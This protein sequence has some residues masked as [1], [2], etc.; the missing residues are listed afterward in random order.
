M[1]IARAAAKIETFKTIV[2]KHLLRKKVADDECYKVM[3]LACFEALAILQGDEAKFAKCLAQALKAN[4]GLG[5][6]QDFDSCNTDKAA[7][8]I[9][10]LAHLCR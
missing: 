9:K 2:G 8:Y 1:N 3:S 5:W 6:G 10:L 7:L 4:P